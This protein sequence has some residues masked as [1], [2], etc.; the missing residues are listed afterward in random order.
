MK[1]KLKRILRYLNKYKWRYLFCLMAIIWF[2]IFCYIPMFGIILSV[3]DYSFSGG[4]FKSEFADPWYKWFDLFFTNP[5]FQTMLWNTVKISLL[6]LV[7]GFP[8]PLLLALALN[9]IKHPKFKKFVQSVSYLPFFVSWVIVSTMLNQLLTP[10][11]GGG[12]LNEFFQLFNG[13]EAK[14]YMGDANSFYPIIILTNIWKGIGWNSI[15]YLAAISSINP[16]LYESAALD[17]ANRFQC[18]RYI[19]IPALST[20]IGLLFILTLGSLSSAGYDQVYVFMHPGNYDYSN[21]LDTYVIESGLNKG[22]YEI[23]TVANLFQSVISF[24]IICIGNY[25]M[26]KKTGVS[27]W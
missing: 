14:Y 13:G 23:A 24:A 15:I 21:I 12:P 7:T 11:N 16:E 4:I 17:G 26:R 25:V 3:K 8:A 22:R 19:T 9:E 18:M 6:K 20:T 10:Y 5:D 1:R 2:T 27:L